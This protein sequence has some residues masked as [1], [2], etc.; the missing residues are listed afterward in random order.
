MGGGLKVCII[1][2]L[3]LVFTKDFI[4]VFNFFD[5]K[6]HLFFQITIIPLQNPLPRF[7]RLEN[8]RNFEIVILLN[9]ISLHYP[10]YSFTL[11]VFL[12]TMASDFVELKLIVLTLCRGF[13]LSAEMLLRGFTFLRVIFTLV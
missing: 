7:Y 12:G 2:F 4:S 11:I 9:E 13:L 10:C 6:R 8:F 1:L 3:L 5:L